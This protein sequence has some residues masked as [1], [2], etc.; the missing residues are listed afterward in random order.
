MRGTGPAQ[1]VAPLD[2]ATALAKGRGERPG[3]EGAAVKGREDAAR[4]GPPQ[5]APPI[6]AARAAAPAG[7]LPAPVAA[8]ARRVTAAFTRS[9]SA[10]SETRI[11][12]SAVGSRKATRASG[13]TT[14]E[15]RTP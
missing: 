15:T 6:R 8:P 13:T 2:P 9:T 4:V 7:A 3:S 11:G 1:R 12:S 10:R 14:T 5:V